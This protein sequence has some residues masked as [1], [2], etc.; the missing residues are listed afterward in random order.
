MLMVLHAESVCK[1][2]TLRVWV[3]GNCVVGQPSSNKCAANATA[4]SDP[5]TLTHRM[6][7]EQQ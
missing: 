7:R 4:C 1:I 2:N 5:F 3:K 6:N